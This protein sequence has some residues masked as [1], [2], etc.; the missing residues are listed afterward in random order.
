MKVLL[1]CREVIDF[2]DRFL[3]GELSDSEA[4]KFRWHLRLC[5]SCRAYLR[6]Y[7]A[8]LAL[9]ADSREEA[10]GP[11]PEELVVAILRSRG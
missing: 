9:E 6:T 10:A 8:T 4:R 5:R 11:I 2:I 3:S 7:R 1:T